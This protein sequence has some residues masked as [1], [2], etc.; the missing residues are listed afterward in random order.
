MPK[1]IGH[2]RRHGTHAPGAQPL[3]TPVRI[4][5]NLVGMVMAVAITYLAARVMAHTLLDVTGRHVGDGQRLI[6]GWP[7][8]PW[9]LRSVL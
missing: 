6:G 3:S 1:G 5:I 9:W 8:M 2:S 4:L 7:P